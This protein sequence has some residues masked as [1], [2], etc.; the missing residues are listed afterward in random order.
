MKTD[1]EVFCRSRP[2]VSRNYLELERA[3]ALLKQGPGCIFESG[4][5]LTEVTV[6]IRDDLMRQ[7]VLDHFDIHDGLVSEIFISL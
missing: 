7:A 3:G 2:G 6:V 5:E 4:E 1:C